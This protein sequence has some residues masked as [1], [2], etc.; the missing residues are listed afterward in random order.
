MIE[1]AWGHLLHQKD[2]PLAQWYRRRTADLGAS[3]PMRMTASWFR[4]AWI[5]RIQVCG[6]MLAPD[7]ELSS[8]S[9]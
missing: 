9:S 6:A 8:V 1:L 2:S 5:D 3:P 7:G 4:S